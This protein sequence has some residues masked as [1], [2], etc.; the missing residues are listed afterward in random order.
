MLDT[1]PAGRPFG[2]EL[3]LEMR[4]RELKEKH[5]QL[6]AELGHPAAFAV[7]CL[8]RFGQFDVR[9]LQPFAIALAAPAQ[10]RFD[11]CHVAH[12]RRRPVARVPG[13]R[14]PRPLLAGDQI[15]FPQPELADHCL[16]DFEIGRADFLAL[17]RDLLALLV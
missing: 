17:V 3:G 1:R 14:P 8:R 11:R 15:D 7:P 16:Q 13:E 10:E 4:C 9:Q 5:Q 2:V 12:D 6:G